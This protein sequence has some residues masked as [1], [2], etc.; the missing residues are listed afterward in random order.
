MDSLG[1]PVINVAAL[2]LLFYQEKTPGGSKIKV[3]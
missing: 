2:L 1:S 3:S